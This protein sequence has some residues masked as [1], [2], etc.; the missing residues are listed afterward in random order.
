MRNLL[1]DAIARE[2]AGEAIDRTRVKDIS[3][4]LMQLGSDDDPW[5]VY[6]AVSTGADL[7]A[8]EGRVAG[9]GCA[10][11]SSC[12]QPHPSPTLPAQRISGNPTSCKPPNTTAA[13]ANGACQPWLALVRQRRALWASWVL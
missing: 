13:S 9:G 7:A 6:T 3:R 2:R 12:D 5:D 1:L 8:F 11:V 10:D 4:M